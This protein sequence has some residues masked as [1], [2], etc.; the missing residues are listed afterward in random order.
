[1]EVYQEVLDT[2]QNVEENL[3]TCDINHS[4]VKNCLF[5]LNNLKK[6]LAQ[7]NYYIND[8]HATAAEARS[9]RQATNECLCETTTTSAQEAT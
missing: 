3:K 6:D 8:L 5:K 4:N 9:T 1:M 7:I 2:W